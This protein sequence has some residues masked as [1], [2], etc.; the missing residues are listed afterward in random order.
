MPEP[1][2][3]GGDQM[4]WADLSEQRWSVHRNV[5]NLGAAHAADG[6]SA[7]RADACMR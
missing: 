3:A 7:P 5:G 4:L 6:V 1:L 2:R